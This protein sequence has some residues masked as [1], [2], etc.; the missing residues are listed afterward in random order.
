MNDSLIAAILLQAENPWAKPEDLPDL[1][2]SLKSNCYS[3]YFGYLSYF[4]GT[5]KGGLEDNYKNISQFITLNTQEVITH[6]DT[7]ALLQYAETLLLDATSKVDKKLAYK[8]G[9]CLAL[10]AVY[11]EDLSRKKA[12]YLQLAKL[13]GEKGLLADPQSLECC[14]LFLAPLTID[15]KFNPTRA[16]IWSWE[17]SGKKAATFESDRQILI[18]T[19]FANQPIKKALFMLGLSDL[20]LLNKDKIQ[21]ACDRC[22]KRLQ[23]LSD[24]SFEEAAAN[25]LLKCFNEAQNLLLHYQRFIGFNYKDRLQSLE[26]LLLQVNNSEIVHEEAFTNLYQAINEFDLELN[27]VLDIVQIEPPYITEETIVEHLG[28]YT[29]ETKQ[30]QAQKQLHILIGK[31]WEDIYAKVS[32][33]LIV[34]NELLANRE[35]ISVRVGPLIEFVTK[36]EKI[37][38][39]IAQI[40]ELQLKKFRDISIADNVA[41]QWDEL[42][43]AMKKVK[44]QIDYYKAWVRINIRDLIHLNEC[45][46]L[47]EM[48]GAKETDALHQISEQRSLNEHIGDKLEWLRQLKGTAKIIVESELK[49]QA[50]GA[51]TTAYESI[52]SMRR[53]LEAHRSRLLIF[54]QQGSGKLNE[55]L[56]QDI[57]ALLQQYKEADKRLELCFQERNSMTFSWEK[58]WSEFLKQQKILDNTFTTL[59]KKI[60]SDYDTADYITQST[61]KFILKLRQQKIAFE[62]KIA[63]VKKKIEQGTTDTFHY[64]LLKKRIEQVVKSFAT[65]DNEDL[66]QFLQKI[67][68]ISSDENGQRYASLVQLIKTEQNELGTPREFNC[69]G[70]YC[71]S[72]THTPFT[73][74]LHQSDKL[75][76]LIAHRDCINTPLSLDTMKYLIL[77]NQLVQ[78]CTLYLEHGTHH[79]DRKDSITRLTQKIAELDL[80]DGKQGDRFEALYASLKNE[81]AATTSSHLRIGF[82]PSWHLCRLQKVYGAIMQNAEHISCLGSEVIEASTLSV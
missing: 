28:G 67:E 1:N 38:G 48:E 30:Y 17:L 4:S 22:N 40:K 15:T 31:F 66:A 27:E 29:G 44:E 37:S 55:L 33:M 24:I 26:N 19:E 75:V 69:F 46:V 53:N 50:F 60:P 49:N 8:A 43:L 13:F 79:Q 5:L 42:G 6:L 81:V 68:Q 39:L 7:D 65:G 14:N 62:Q 73:P 23:E 74:I 56:Q 2:T 61:A 47:N 77:K 35:N 72:R 45:L 58:K 20:D 63:E 10:V 25:P 16:I 80:Q 64:L 52:D 11:S 41:Q 51:S 54:K 71:S 57:S 78:E 82:F 9:I 18:K 36:A 12:A 34:I 32:P 3:S 76:S 59:N 70:W 21:A